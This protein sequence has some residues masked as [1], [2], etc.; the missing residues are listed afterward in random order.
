MKELLRIDQVE[1][2][3]NIVLE[4]GKI[5][6]NFWQSR[7][8]EISRKPDNSRVTSADIAVSKFIRHGLSKITPD[9]SVIC[10]EGEL[11][12]AKQ[13]FWLVDPIDGTSA[14]I[15]GSNE[16]SVNIALIKDNKAIFGIIYSPL[17][18]DGKMVF[19]NEDSVFISSHSKERRKLEYK[20]YE[21]G[22]TFK[23]VTSSRTKDGDV[24]NF[25]KQFYPQ[26]L[27]DFEV[28]KLS[29]S[30]KFFRVLENNCD[31]YL[32]FRPSMEWD[33]AAGQALVELMGGKVKN[34]SFNQDKFL[35]KDEMSYSKPGF[36]NSSFIVLFNK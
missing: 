25:I 19:C 11:R 16:F 5:A 4:A 28:E 15:E 2:V 21:I 10:E 7:D 8:F 34:L 20:H 32:H 36:N 13:I 31:I 18:E 33:I 3:I 23:V 29:S 24:S 12:D 30:I 1:E 9:I 22:K 35:I 27:N 17:F 26:F 6:A 14:F